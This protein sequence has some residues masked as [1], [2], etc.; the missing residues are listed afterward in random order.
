MG[1]G[2]KSCTPVFHSWHSSFGLSLKIHQNP[3]NQLGN[4]WVPADQLGGKK[5][6]AKQGHFLGLRADYL[7][8]ESLKM[9]KMYI[10]R[11]ITRYILGV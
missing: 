2:K 4:I 9:F 10:V 6:W 8:D 11:R 3:G 1:C 7:N 5:C